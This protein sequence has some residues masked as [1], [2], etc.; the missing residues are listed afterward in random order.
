MRATMEQSRAELPG[1]AELHALLAAAL[2]E[3]VVL[4]DRLR[5]VFV[6]QREALAA[7]DPAA[8]DDGVFAATRVLRTL[9]EAR[10]RRE[11]LMTG[12][13]GS[14]VELDELDTFLTGQA[15]RAIR[16]AQERLR[17]AAAA[18]REEV[19]ILRRILQVALAD[20]R[21][22]LD[23]LLGDGVTGGRRDG[24]YEPEGAGSASTE[25][26]GVVLDRTV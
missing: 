19:S 6:A 8:L 14:E 24:G 5:K 18:L 1:Q 2:E 23:V 10:R 12:L 16:L 21:R 15:G 11:R 25:P 22:Y 13:V 9:D 3:E 20:N 4:L 7:S 26:A 17:G